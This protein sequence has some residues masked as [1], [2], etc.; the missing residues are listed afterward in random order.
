ME[1]KVKTGDP[2]GVSVAVTRKVTGWVKVTGAA[3]VGL[4][5]QEGREAKRA[6]AKPAGMFNKMYFLFTSNS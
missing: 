6:S 5:V 1:V 3:V 4:F 2:V